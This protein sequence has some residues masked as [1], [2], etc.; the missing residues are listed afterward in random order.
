MEP[1][2]HLHIKQNRAMADKCRPQV[3]SHADRPDLYDAGYQPIAAY[4]RTERALGARLPQTA[5]SLCVA[6]SF[7][8]RR[9]YASIATGV[10]RCLGTRRLRSASSFRAWV[11]SVGALDGE[12]KPVLACGLLRVS[13]TAQVPL[14][15]GG[16]ASNAAGIPRLMSRA[17]V[18]LELS[19]SECW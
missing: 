3:R 18:F 9:A 13:Q 12:T 14:G 5:L 17:Q 7:W 2:H 6:G 4:G 10:R 1:H 8:R 15:G 16:P 11:R 19:Y